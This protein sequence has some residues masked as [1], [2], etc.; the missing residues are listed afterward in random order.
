MTSS[1]SMLRRR[2]FA[3]LVVL[4]WATVPLA[5]GTTWAADA[6]APMAAGLQAV[7]ALIVPLT[8]RAAPDAAWARATAAPAWS[9]SLRSWSLPPPGR[10]TRSTCT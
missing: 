9:A 7:L 1:L 2:A 3:A 10:P 6:S 4:L 5:A 8:W